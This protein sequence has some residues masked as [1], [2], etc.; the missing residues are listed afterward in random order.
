VKGV[1]RTATGWRIAQADR[2]GVRWTP[3]GWRRDSRLE[4]IVDPEDA[5]TTEALAERLAACRSAR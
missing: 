5:L 2:D 3:T 1:F 4:V